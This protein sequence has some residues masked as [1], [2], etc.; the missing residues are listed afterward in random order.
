MNARPD[1]SDA[2]SN[3]LVPLARPVDDVLAVFRRQSKFPDRCTTGLSRA[4][5]RECGREMIAGPLCTPNLGLS[6]QCRTSA[7][8]SAPGIDPV[9]VLEPVDR[10]GTTSFFFSASSTVHCPSHHVKWKSAKRRI[11][12]PAAIASIGP[13]IEAYHSRS[14]WKFAADVYKASQFRIVPPPGGGGGV[15]RSLTDLF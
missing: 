1:K 12:L 8:A 3:S 11:P 7:N 2:G 6:G 9:S 13:S 5:S 14:E 15:T 10:A 4:A